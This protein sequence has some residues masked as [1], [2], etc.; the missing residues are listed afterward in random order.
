MKCLLLFLCILS[1]TQAMPHPGTDENVNNALFRLALKLL[2]DKPNESAVVSPFSVGM[3]LSTINVGG[4]GKTSDEITKEA[5][6]GMSKNIVDSWFKDTIRHLQSARDNIKLASAIYAEKTIDILKSYQDSLKIS[7]NTKVNK[8]DFIDQHKDQR[9][10]INEFVKSVTSGNI[11]EVLA[12]NDVSSA[13][14]FVAVN[15]LHVKSQF[16]HK[17]YKED[18]KKADF[19]KEGKSTKKV[20]MMH[21]TLGG[22]YFETK[23][24]AYAALSF[25]SPGL[26][27]FLIVP[28]TGTLTALKE[29]FVSATHKYTAAT[30]QA[31]YF[32][33][34]H[35][36]MPKIN[37]NVHLNLKDAMKKHGVTEMFASKADFSGISKDK[38]IVDDIIHQAKIDVDEEGVTASAAT[39]L[40]MVGGAGF[41][42]ENCEATIVADKPFIFGIAHGRTPL[43]VGQYY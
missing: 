5:F 17:F 34:L 20:D 41:C 4:K 22:T 11:P 3:A 25:N 2:D 19:H 39:V 13:T 28:K 18:T 33:E 31:G 16:A 29:K 26:S 36:T 30:N 42:R 38:L 27:L 43:F 23:D 15:V 1:L 12:K 37:Q 8:V 21:R 14:R 6:N 9:A 10:A 7:Y 35:V 24:Y 32:P 40:S